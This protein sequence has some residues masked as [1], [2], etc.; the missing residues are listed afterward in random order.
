MKKRS[1]E[2]SPFEVVYTKPPRH[3]LD[4]VDLPKVSGLSQATKQ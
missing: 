3:T 4:L 1:T 2:K